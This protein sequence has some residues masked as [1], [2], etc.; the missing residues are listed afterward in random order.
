MLKAYLVKTK[1]GKYGTFYH[2]DRFVNDKC[3][4][5][6]LDEQGVEMKKATLCDPVHLK[7]IL[8]IGSKTKK[9]GKMI[10]ITTVTSPE[11][12]YKII[13][14]RRLKASLKTKKP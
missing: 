4:V 1:H 3:P 14:A 5:Y 6:I 2:K 7:I 10:S 9:V 8:S 12:T 13:Q 11:D